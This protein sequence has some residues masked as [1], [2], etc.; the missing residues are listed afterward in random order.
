MNNGVEKEM[1]L[2]QNQLLLAERKTE[3]SKN[4][5]IQKKK[6][7]PKSENHR[8]TNY[9]SRL[10]DVTPLVVKTQILTKNNKR[11]KQRQNQCGKWKNHTRNITLRRPIIIEVITSDDTSCLSDSSSIDYN[12][13]LNVINEKSEV[14]RLEHVYNIIHNVE[15]GKKEE[16][17]QKSVLHKD[18]QNEDSLDK[19]LT[20]SSSMSLNSSYT[21]IDPR[22]ITRRFNWRIL[23]QQE[24]K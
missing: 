19:E 14:R 6:M 7:L 17:I 1:R 10:N 24:R 15:D 8:K 4:E 5:C 20:N 11:N 18:D 13:S 21:R 12:N 2:V 9:V 23:Y 22:R 3:K 16:R